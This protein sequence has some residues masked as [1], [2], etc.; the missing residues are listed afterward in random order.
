MLS[1]DDSLRWDC[2]ECQEKGLDRARN[3][4][5]LNLE[6]GEFNQAAQ[7]DFAPNLRQCPK[8]LVDDEAEAALAWWQDWKHLGL[9]PFPGEMR[10]QP[11]QVVEAMKIAAVEWDDAKQRKEAASEAGIQRALHGLGGKGG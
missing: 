7:W 2:E 10:D 11:A 9:L 5:F 1:G 3:C 4:A 8:S 6:E